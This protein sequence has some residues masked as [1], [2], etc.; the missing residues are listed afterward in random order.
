MY[1]I[2]TGAS[3]GIGMEM[4]RCLLSR[5]DIVLVARR[6]ERLK[7]LTKEFNKLS[8]RHKYTHKVE[9][10][11]CDVSNVDECKALYEKY[12]SDDVQVL[13]NGAGF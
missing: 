12:K 5:Y 1:A 7:E 9:Y 3:S 4:A 6:E 11:R 13:I 10:F 2:I 8:V